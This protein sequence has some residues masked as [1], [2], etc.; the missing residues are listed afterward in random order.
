MYMVRLS[1]NAQ[2]WP[3]TSCFAPKWLFFLVQK[4]FPLAQKFCLIE[5]VILSHHMYLY[6]NVY[7]QDHQVSKSD[8]LP[9]APSPSAFYKSG[10]K[11]DQTN[12]RNYI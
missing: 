5:C 4:N 10:Q 7:G 2:N 6:L 3:K 8:P 11:S 1:K 12:K 9:V